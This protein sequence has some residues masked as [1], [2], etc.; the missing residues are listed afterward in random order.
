MPAFVEALDVAS[1]L[2]VIDNSCIKQTLPP[3]SFLL[4]TMD[5]I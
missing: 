4:A 1:G 5:D 3:H 2:V